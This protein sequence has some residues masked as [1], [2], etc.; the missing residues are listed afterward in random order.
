MYLSQ[1]CRHATSL[2]VLSLAFAGT[3]AVASACPQPDRRSMPDCALPDITNN[4]QNYT[5]KNNCEFKIKVVITAEDGE[6]VAIPIDPGKHDF[7]SLPDYN[8]IG[9]ISCCADEHPP[10]YC[11]RE[12]WVQEGRKMN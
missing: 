8:P 10:Y 2:A 7:A 4:N 6:E 9:S 11:T 1:V 3:L 12:D 5:I